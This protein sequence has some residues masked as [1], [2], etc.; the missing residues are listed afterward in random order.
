MGN[1]HELF[2]AYNAI[3]IDQKDKGIIEEVTDSS[4]TGTRKH[5]IPHHPVVNLTRSSTKVRIVYDAS[6][7]QEKSQPSLNDCLYRGPVM[8]HHLCGLLL[9]FRTHKLSLMADIEKAFL[10][11]GLQPADRDVTRF[12]WVKNENIPQVKNNLQ[13]YRFTRV[14]FGIISSPFL[15]S[16]TIAYH[17]NQ[18]K[19]ETA[20][21]RKE[22]IYVDNV[23]TGCDSIEEANKFYME[24]KHIFSKA[25]INLRDWSSNSQEFLQN[26]PETDKAKGEIIKVLGLMWY[27][28]ADTPSIPQCGTANQITHSTKREA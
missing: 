26:M 7:K 17:L 15:L 25:S 9:R 12:L 16:A 18:S 19:T 4:V 6:A 14:P 10:Q 22:N 24:S 11:V 3:I 5:Y 21:Q 28:E 23:V 13:V 1:N 8:L 2:N 20:K 27:P